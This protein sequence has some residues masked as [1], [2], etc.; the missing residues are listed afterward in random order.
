[1]VMDVNALENLETGLV[2]AGLD[3]LRQIGGDEMMRRIVGQATLVGLSDE[4]GEPGVPIVDYLRYRNTALE[5]LGDTF[6]TIAFETGRTL[7]RNLR[8][9]K[10]DE[11]RALVQTL[12]QTENKLFLIGQ[13]AVLAAKENPGIVRASFPSESVLAIT[14]EECPECRGLRRRMPFC[15]L[16]QGIITEFADRYL[17]VKVLTVE[18]KCMAQ[19]SPFCQ[20]EVSLAS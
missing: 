7:V 14:I 20:T 6:Q 12:G 2:L 16:N 3:A 10:V 18:T 5:L 11:I 15:F 9:R 19:G 1:M 4:E 17:G 8:H 13:A